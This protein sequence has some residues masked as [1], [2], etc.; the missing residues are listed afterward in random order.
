MYGD[1][2]IDNV[3]VKCGCYVKCILKASIRTEKCIKNEEIILVISKIRIWKNIY[4]PDF[5]ERYSGNV[6]K[7]NNWLND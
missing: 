1:S 2:G 7:Y 4:I 5:N 6:D 3:V